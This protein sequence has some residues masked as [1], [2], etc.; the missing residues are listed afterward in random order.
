MFQRIVPVLLTIVLAMA[1][2]RCEAV[3]VYDKRFPDEPI[4]GFLV[5]DTDTSLVVRQVLVNGKETTRT[6][7]KSDV[8]FILTVDRMRLGELNPAEPKDYRDYAEELS[9]KRQDPEARAT[10]IR[11]YLIAAH[12][13]GNALGRSSLLGMVNL[14]RSANEEAKFRAM[15]Y[16]LDP[17]HDERV[18]KRPDP[19]KS[20]PTTLNDKSRLAL[21]NTLRY[22]RQGYIASARRAFEQSETREAISFFGEIITEKEINAAIRPGR[23]PQ[24]MLKKF[25]LI[26]LSLLPNSGDIAPPMVD[27]R[28]ASWLDA[29]DRD[30]KAPVPILTLET[31]S[32]FKPTQCVFREGRWVEE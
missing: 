19:V 9:E 23:L 24:T 8:D 12:L 10:A 5:R 25:L 1:A 31:L 27:D 13:D 15:A 20:R 26:E 22:L 11:L 29:I 30:G 28:T 16:L 6:F 2:A 3:V 18:L 4:M 14:A 21:L 32:E 7:S 17:E